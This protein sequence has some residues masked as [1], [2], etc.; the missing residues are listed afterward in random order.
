MIR[1]YIKI[2]E[3]FVRHIFKDGFWFVHKPFVRMVKF[4]QIAQFP[5]DHLPNPF[6]QVFIIPYILFLTIVSRWFFSGIWGYSKSP[7]FSRT[8]LTILADINNAVVWMVSTCPLIFKSSSPFT[9]LLGIVPSALITTGINVTLTS[10]VY[11]FSS[12]A[13]SWYLSLFLL[14]FNFIEVYRDDRVHYLV[15][16]ITWCNGYR[17]RKWTRRHEFK[18]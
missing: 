4:K 16:T 15:T 3:N 8:L 5:V 12:L 18:S 7:L 9:N 1:F 17:R 14:S 13:K 10:L 2:A 11:V 6:V